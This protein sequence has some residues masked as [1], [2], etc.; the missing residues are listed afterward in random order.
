VLYATD[1]SAGSVNALHSAYDVSR[2]HDAKLV[3]LQVTREP[4]EE[5]LFDDAVITTFEKLQDW[6]HNHVVAYGDG[7]MGRAQCLIKFG[8]AAQQVVETAHELHPEMIVI[9]ARGMSAGSQVD[10]RFVGDTAFEI[11]CSAG[12]PVLIVPDLSDIGPGTY[13]VTP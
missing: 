8:E 9:G 11:A 7:A 10:E 1:L 6:L 3:V 2:N 12:C 5:I 13:D 4:N